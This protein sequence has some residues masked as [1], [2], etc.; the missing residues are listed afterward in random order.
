M[1]LQNDAEPECYHILRTRLDSTSSVDLSRCLFSRLICHCG[2]IR[3][4]IT[5]KSCGGVVFSRL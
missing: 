4:N 1:E 2:G 3:G 5:Y